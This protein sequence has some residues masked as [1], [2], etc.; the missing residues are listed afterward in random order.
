MLPGQWF[1]GIPMPEYELRFISSLTITVAWLAMV[2]GDA[3]SGRADESN[4]TIAD[5]AGLEFFEKHVR[6]VLVEH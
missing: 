4:A 5:A 3:A 2:A 1:T 6:P